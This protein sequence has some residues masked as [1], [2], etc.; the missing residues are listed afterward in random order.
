MGIEDR[1]RDH[2]ALCLERQVEG[3]A[4]EALLDEVQFLHEALP[5]ID[6]NAIDLGQSFL[7]RRLT[8]PLLISGMTGG[9]PR[10]VEINQALAELAQRRGIAL[11]VGSQRAML[12]DPERSH[13]YR[14]RRF[15]PD[16]ALVANL[17]AV[18][19]RDAG[20]KAVGELVEAIDADAFCVHLN[21]AQEIVQDEGDRDFRGCLDAI[22]SIVEALPVPVIVKETGCGLSPTVAEQLAQIG[23]AYLDVAGRG[24]TSWTRVESYRGPES[25]RDLGS[26]LAEWG[27][28]TAASLLFA[29]DRGPRIIAS[30]G[31]RTGLDVARGIALGADLGGMALPFLRAF[32][33]EGSDGLDA[34]VS[35]IER[36]LR[37][38]CL[39]TASKD[40]A[41]LR[42]TPVHL[43]PELRSWQALDPRHR[44]PGFVELDAP[45]QHPSITRGD[46]LLACGG[47]YPPTPTT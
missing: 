22:A 3:A 39:L 30:G 40:L 38:V 1:K 42:R 4:V 20:A 27:I 28:P 33:S 7:G 32:E 37:A 5:E 23:V 18:Q 47:D 2:V 36:D 19:V 44:H 35:E 15:A 16:A 10:A 34:L 24:G 8:L 12:E 9:H 31:M 21:P 6:R 43:G 11:G 26:R 13:G 17:G 14:L 29:R 45:A 41:A 46:V 25:Q